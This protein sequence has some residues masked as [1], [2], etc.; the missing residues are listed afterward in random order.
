MLV[1]DSAGTVSWQPIVLVKDACAPHNT[2]HLHLHLHL[3][4][5]PRLVHH[6]REAQPRKKN[7]GPKAGAQFLGR[8]T[9]FYQK[10]MLQL[11]M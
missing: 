8:T 7:P 10:V 4:S 9:H 2:S 1:R 5:R 3:Q 11:L 6:A